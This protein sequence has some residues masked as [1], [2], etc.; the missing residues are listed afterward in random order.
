MRPLILIFSLA[1]TLSAF[2]AKTVEVTTTSANGQLLLS[3]QSIK[4]GSNIGTANSIITLNA[5]QK[6]QRMDGFGFALTYSAC[7]NMMKMTA[8]DRHNLLVKTFSPTDGFGVNYVRMSIACSDFSSECY[9]YCDKKGPSDNLLANFTLHDD[10]LSYVIPVMKEVLAINPQIKIM[11]A[12]WTAPR[13]MKQ[14]SVTDTSAW[15]YYVGGVLNP[16]YYEAYA[17]Y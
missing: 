6:Y 16:T 4:L 2:S 12:P 7:Y 5:E 10:E 15:N 14:K 13:W 3:K 9:T 17:Q 11:A 8:Q 1:L